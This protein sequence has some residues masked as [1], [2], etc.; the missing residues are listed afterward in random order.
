M[1][2]CEGRDFGI[3]GQFSGTD[4][5]ERGLSVRSPRTNEVLGCEVNWI[6]G[7]SSLAHPSF[8]KDKEVSEVGRFYEGG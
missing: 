3:K 6:A 7:P 8:Q 1:F 5:M 4:K 2:D